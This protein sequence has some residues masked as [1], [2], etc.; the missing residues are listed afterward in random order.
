MK[1]RINK[2]CVEKNI[3][4]NQ[5]SIKYPN[6]KKNHPPPITAAGILGPDLVIPDLKYT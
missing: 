6:T 4:S 1:N 3:N 5:V 2:S